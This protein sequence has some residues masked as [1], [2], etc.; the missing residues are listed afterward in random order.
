MG[1][2]RYQRAADELVRTRF[3]HVAFDGFPSEI[4][5][6]SEAEGYLIRDVLAERLADRGFGRRVGYKIGCTTEVMQQYLKISSPC[7]GSVYDTTVQYGDGSFNLKDYVR[8]G[9]ECEIAVRLSRDLTPRE[10]GFTREDVASAVESCMVAMELVDDRYTDFTQ[11]GAP[12]LIA[13]DFFGAGGVL[14]AEIRDFD[15]FDLATVTASMS[16][17]G[18]SVGSGVGSDV[19]GHPLDALRW[20]AGNESDRASGGLRAGEFVLLGS[21]VKTNWID[22]PCEVRIINDQLGEIVARFQ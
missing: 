3:D 18:T 22:G 12:T 8:A 1:E 10:Q 11:L 4:R 21:L 7:A 19:L 2:T 6:E 17:D 16:I 5:P 9:V 14:G 20:L 15:P 13:D